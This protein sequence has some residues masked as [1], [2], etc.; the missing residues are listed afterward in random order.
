MDEEK[1]VEYVNQQCDLIRRLLLPGLHERLARTMLAEMKKGPSTVDLKIKF[2]TKDLGIDLGILETH[3]PGFLVAYNVFA[4]PSCEYSEEQI[5]I[6]PAY[7][8]RPCL[9][10][11]FPRSSSISSMSSSISSSSDPSSLSSPS[12]VKGPRTGSFLGNFMSAASRSAGNKHRQLKQRIT[13]KQVLTLKN[14][15]IIDSEPEDYFF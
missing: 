9:D 7:Y 4:A 8:G 15:H 10:S 14:F 5:L 11:L 13:G 2:S 3:L 1:S 6:E 12:S